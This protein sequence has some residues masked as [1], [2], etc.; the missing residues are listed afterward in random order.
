VRTRLTLAQ[1][2]A[3]LAES[4]TRSIR[5]QAC[6]GLDL[7]TAMRARELSHLT[8]QHVDLAARSLLITREPC[9][10]EPKDHEEGVLWFSEETAKLLKKLYD[11]GRNEH[12]ERGLSAEEAAVLLSGSRV[13]GSGH[14]SLED[15]WERA[16]NAELRACC[17]AAGVPEITSHGLRRSAA[18][19]AREAGAEAR[20][21]Q[22]MLRHSSFS[23]T[24]L[25]IGDDQ[26]DAAHRAHRALQSVPKLC[27]RPESIPA[28]SAKEI[29]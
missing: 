12:V 14:S 16:Y 21:I 17:R 6:L 23:T 29:A 13:F 22:A 7:D 10:W 2:S 15:K 11:A 26:A 4:A 19:H 18:R 8:W 1:T 25:Y 28:Q 20:D 5:F 24:R 27:H 3:L 9:G